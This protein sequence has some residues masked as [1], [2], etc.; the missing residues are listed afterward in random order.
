[1]I[2]LIKKIDTSEHDLFVNG[3]KVIAISLS[4]EELLKDDPNLQPN[5]PKKEPLVKY[6]LADGGKWVHTTKLIVDVDSK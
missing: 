6:H 1:M 5:N 4:Y 3:E 2:K